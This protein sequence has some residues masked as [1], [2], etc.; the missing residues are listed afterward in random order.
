MVDFFS[1]EEGD[2]FFRHL[3]NQRK[4]KGARLKD[5]TLRRLQ[6]IQQADSQGVQE[7]EM[8]ESPT[9]GRWPATMEFGREDVTQ[10]RVELLG[11]SFA[12]DV[13]LGQTRIL[14]L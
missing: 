11:L 5:E 4:A 14:M 6:R 2:Q 10:Q 3:P 8:R 7:A 9:L 12:V 1:S 13:C